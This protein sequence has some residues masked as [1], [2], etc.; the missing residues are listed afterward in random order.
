[1]VLDQRL[2]DPTAEPTITVKRAAGV[3][4]ISSRS[5]YDAAARGEWP[6]IRVGRSVRVL[7]ARFLEQYGLSDPPAAA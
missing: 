2:P 6:V 4:R 3:V 7:T 1:M 5:G